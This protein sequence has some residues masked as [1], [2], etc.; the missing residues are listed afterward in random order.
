MKILQ[1]FMQSSEK[2]HEPGMSRRS[3]LKV[4]GGATAGLVVGYYLPAAGAR[5]AAGDGTFNPFVRIAPDGTVTVLNKHLD[6][7][8]GNMTGLLSLVAEEMDANWEQMAGDFAPSDPKK[9]ANLK[10][11]SVQGTGGS[12]AIPNSFM[13]YREAGA[14]AKAMLVAAAAKAWGVKADEINVENGVISHPSGKK[15]GFGAFAAAASAETLP[16]KPKLKSPDQFKYIGKTG[17][18]RVDSNPKSTGATVYTQDVDRPGMQVA[19]VARP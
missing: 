16:E 6:M 8:Q 1:H 17:Y 7:G 12:S 18:G 3:F 14:A 19:M 13:Q 10:W 4:S 9:Y 11:G 15:A 2:A 5:A